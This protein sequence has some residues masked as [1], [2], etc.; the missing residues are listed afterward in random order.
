MSER[1][2]HLLEIATR[3]PRLKIL[4]ASTLSAALLLSS[5]TPE[6][7]PMPKR[8]TIGSQDPKI[9]EQLKDHGATVFAG[10]FT[11]SAPLAFAQV[12]AKL[13]VETIVVSPMDET[14]YYQVELPDKS[15][16]NLTLNLGIQGTEIFPDHGYIQAS[17]V[18]QAPAK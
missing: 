14:K 8:I 16:K 11:E 9:Q 1:L 17:S 18:I 2:S 5:A 7:T 6:G 4:G 12:G 3:N 15:T 10:P 13:N